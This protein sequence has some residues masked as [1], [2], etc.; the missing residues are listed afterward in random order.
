MLPFI[1]STNNFKDPIFGDDDLSKITLGVFSEL[2]GGV[3]AALL[4]ELKSFGRL[5]SMKLCYS[6][7]SLTAFPAYFDIETRFFFWAN[8]CKFLLGMTFVFVY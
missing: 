2:L 6:L 3:I 7:Q 5:N 1:L 4:I 8:L